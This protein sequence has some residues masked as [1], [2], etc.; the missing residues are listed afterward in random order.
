[1]GELRK[2]DRDSLLA[3]IQELRKTAVKKPL[4]EPVKRSLKFTTL[5]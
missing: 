3:E 5:L 1:M 4:I 2:K